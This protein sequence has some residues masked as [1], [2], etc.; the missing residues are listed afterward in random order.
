ME[1]KELTSE[2]IEE[3]LS[4]TYKKPKKAGG[5]DGMSYADH[6]A[7]AQERETDSAYHPKNRTRY[8]WFSRK[9]EAA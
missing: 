3:C 4:R 7:K 1:K 2:E 6:F 9:K 8:G 5:A